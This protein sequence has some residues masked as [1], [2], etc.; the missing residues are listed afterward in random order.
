MYFDKVYFDKL[1][2]YLFCAAIAASPLL[3]AEEGGAG[4]GEAE[5]PAM[6]WKVLNFL[7]LAG[8]L[9]YLIGKNLGPALTERAKG[10]QEALAAGEK[11]KKEA[12]ARAA[13]VQAKLATLDTEIS[14]LRTAAQ[15]ERDREADR[16]RRDAQSE[17]ERIRTQ[18]QFEIESAGKQAG[19]ELKR[20]AAKLAL[21]LAE[22][23][24]RARMS[25]E[26]E[27]V[28]LDGF[29]AN[30]PDTAPSTRAN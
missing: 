20:Y 6:I 12:E 4:G 18:A 8:G 11:A 19:L 23:K 10:I 22:Q 16:I 17:M 1:K 13:A 7:I 14:A 27:A 30:L 24:V 21:D 25:P 9:G 15:A 28:L 29:L 5:G 2:R 26:A 3:A